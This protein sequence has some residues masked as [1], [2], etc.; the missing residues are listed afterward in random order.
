MQETR[1]FQF[2]FRA[3]LPASTAEDRMRAWFPAPASSEHQTIESAV[4][5]APFPHKLVTDKSF[6]NSGYYFEPPPS[7]TPVPVS[8]TYTATRRIWRNEL[9]ASLER[10]DYE[11][12]FLE[13]PEIERYL[14]PNINV[15]T[16]GFIAY[17]ARSVASQ[18]DPPLHRARA[19]F[20]HL[21]AT[22]TYDWSGCTPDR[23]A[24]L[25]NLKQ[26]CDLRTGT[27]TEWHGLYVGYL[28]ALGV[29]AQFCFGFNLPR[30]PSAQPVPGEQR[31]YH[32]IKG[33]HCWAEILLPEV[34][35]VPVDVTEAWKA[36]SGRRTDDISP[37]RRAFFFGSLDASR[38]QF[39]VG[40]DLELE[41]RPAGPPIDK[42]VFGHLE[43]RGKPQHIKD[44]S[45]SCTDLDPA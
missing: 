20:E 27:C 22:L 42:W 16:E 19:V 10:A 12:G 15:P 11:P 3:V 18:A 29:P 21:I 40:R 13:R 44:L 28:R 2:T 7:S 14:A 39:H 45:F 41:P 34:G 8:F 17:Q 36:T 23:V 4:V 32:E 6:G 24:D 43:I 30:P 31:K 26:A 9:P 33:Y 25:G 38:F 37:E 5:D 1:R 35:W